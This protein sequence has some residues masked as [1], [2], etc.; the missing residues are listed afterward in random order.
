MDS[1]TREQLRRG[2]EALVQRGDAITARRSALEVLGREPDLPPAS[3]LAAQADFVEGRLG[4]ALARLEPWIEEHP[5]Y[6]PSRLLEARLA[7]LSGT[8]IE[9]HAAYRAL[10]AELPVAARGVDETREPALQAL[11]QELAQAL[12][13]GRI[14]EAAARMERLRRWA[15]QG[16]PRILEAEARL[17]RRGGDREAELEALR[18]L[19]EIGGPEPALAERLAELELEAGDAETGIRLLQGLLDRYPESEQLQEKLASAQLRWRVRLLP[20]D[21]QRIVSRPQIGRGEFAALVFWLVPGVR[22][23]TGGSLRI[24]TDI[25]E[26]PL[27]REIVRVVNLGLMRVD[28]TTHRFEPDRALQLSE[29]LASLLAV[30]RSGR[31]ESCA[32]ALELHPAPSERFLC[33]LGRECDLLDETEA[34]LPGSPLS[35]EE[36]LALLGRA[37]RA[38]EGH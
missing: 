10:A 16:S 34:C 24:A 20:E 23:E 38:M 19:H 8:W 18:A 1:E 35:S 31:G 25:L 11:E 5:G 26:H 2:F 37:L 36:A 27:R 29:A 7:E 28:S 21:V 33:E 17:A 30:L 15:P 9:A 3:L 4:P 22:Q 14:D 6:T 13:A 32:E 12:D